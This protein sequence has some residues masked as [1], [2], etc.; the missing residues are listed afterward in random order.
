MSTSKK[1]VLAKVRKI[2]RVTLFTNQPGIVTALVNMFI[3]TFLYQSYFT[4]LFNF[5]LTSNI[6]R[7]PQSRVQFGYLVIRNPFSD[8]VMWLAN[9][10]TPRSSACRFIAGP[11]DIGGSGIMRNLGL[12]KMTEHEA[13]ITNLALSSLA[14]RQ[15]MVYDWYCK[16]RSSSTRLDACQFEFFCPRNYSRFNDCAY[17]NVWLPS[18]GVS[19]SWVSF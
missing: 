18:S 9:G 4:L 5:I 8:T 15:S 6:H 16:Y 11:V 1:N 3:S 13:T 10:S 14:Y 2:W 17:A 7:C 12:P 19:I